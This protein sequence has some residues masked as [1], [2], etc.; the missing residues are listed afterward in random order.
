MRWACSESGSDLTLETGLPGYN[1]RINAG[2]RPSPPEY[3]GARISTAASRAGLSQKKKSRAG[4]RQP[5][6]P[7]FQTG[8]IPAN[9]RRNFKI[10][11]PA[12][13]LTSRFKFRTAQS[14]TSRGAHLPDP[15]IYPFASH[16]SRRV[17]SRVSSSACGWNGTATV[18]DL[19]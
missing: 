12:S 6:A 7:P 18:P 11:P 2:P 1:H 8:R 17:R 5:S 15:T 3:P 16:D 10:P 14:G 9:G 4:Q 19:A 13:G